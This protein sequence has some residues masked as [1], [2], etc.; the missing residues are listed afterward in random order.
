[1]KSIQLQRRTTRLLC[2]ALAPAKKKAHLMLCF[3]IPGRLF[4]T[5][6]C[7]E[8]ARWSLR[9]LTTHSFKKPASQPASQ[10]FVVTHFQSFRRGVAGKKG[11]WVTPDIMQTLHSNAARLETGQSIA[12]C[13]RPVWL[14]HGRPTRK[15][16]WQI[17]RRRVVFIALVMAALD[18]PNHKK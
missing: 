18:T 17:T 3:C 14:R 10:P 1:M 12:G 8:G 9:P 4:H 7:T 6:N 15:D 13:A 2:L 5:S 16:Q 11:K